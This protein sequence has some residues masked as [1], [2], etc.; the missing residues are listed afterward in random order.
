MSMP[1]IRQEAW[2]E[3]EGEVAAS[4]PVSG[5]AILCAIVGVLSLLA[6]FDFALVVFPVGTVILA[7]LAWRHIHKFDPPALGQGAIKFAV[8]LACF[9]GVG[10]PV[11]LLTLR[12][13]LVSE[14][15]TTADQFLALLQQGKPHLAFQLTR[16]PHARLPIEEEKWLSLSG[17]PAA[18]DQYVW[19]AI[20]KDSLSREDFEGFVNR[21]PVRIVL[22]LGGNCQIRY[23]STP[24]AQQRYGK[25]QVHH[26]YAVTYQHEGRKRTVVLA[27]QVER[28]RLREKRQADWVV[29]DVFGPVNPDRYP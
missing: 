28:Q 13:F 17:G 25:Y 20:A 8:V 29:T 22:H 23:Y 10:G 19:D 14:S 18:R 5:L 12:G 7:V 9:G 4:R 27:V 15:R 26:L 3:P 6:F 16:D 1:Q 11:H 21:I 24:V 2:Q